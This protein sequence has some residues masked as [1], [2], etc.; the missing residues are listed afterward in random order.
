MKKVKQLS[1]VMLLSIFVFSASIAN[2]QNRNGSGTK[3]MNGQGIE[4]RIPDLTDTQKE[5]IK[6]LR[7]AHLKDAQQIKNQMGIK[8]AELKALQTAENPDLD[9]INKKIEERS[10]LRLDLEKKS[11][12]HKQSIRALLTDDQK[13]VY[14]KQ[15]SRRGNAAHDCGSKTS[16]P[17]GGS[18]AGHKCK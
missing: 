17:C 10:A 13:V 16:K 14:D 18:K 2:A 7:T 11:A 8:R 5:K 15:T 4:N 9:A 12:A 6:T 1:L 3:Q